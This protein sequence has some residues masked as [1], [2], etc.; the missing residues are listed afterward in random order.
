M[1]LVKVRDLKVYSDDRGN[2]FEMLRSDDKEFK[3]F[4]QVYLVED[5]IPF[6]IRAFHKHFKL[7]DHFC[8][9]HGSGKFV[10]F[11]GDFPAVEN[12][13]KPEIIVL[14]SRRPKLISVPP[15]IWHGWMSLE[16]DTQMVSIASDPYNRENPDEERCDPYIIGKEIWEIKAM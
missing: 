14:D 8:I 5:R 2:L 9:T 11:E 4:G 15:N 16:A 10:F 6:T 13:I 7:W 1:S 3:T 12:K